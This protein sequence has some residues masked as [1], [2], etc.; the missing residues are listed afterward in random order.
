V[1]HQGIDADVVVVGA[2]AA[3][4]VLASR[5]SEDPHR[6]VLLVEAGGSDWNPLLRV[7]LMTGLILRS[8]YA[9][10][11]YVTE[12]EDAL[13]ARRLQWARGKVLGGSTSING[14]VYMRGL[15]LDYDRWDASGLHGWAYR[16][17]LPYFLRSERSHRRDDALHGTQGPMTVSAPRLANPL[18][19]AYREAA[20]QAGWPATDD[21]AGEKPLGVGAYDFNIARGRRVSASSAF[22]APARARPNL[23]VLTGAQALGLIWSGPRRVGGV[24]VRHQGQALSCRAQ[25]EV[26]LC[27][28]AVNSPQLLLLSG[29][30]PADELRRHG[31]DVRVD[32]PGVGQSLQDHL[33]VR[34]EHRATEGVTL[35]RLRRPDRAAW[36]LAQALLWGRGP[37]ASFPLEVGGLYRSGL[38]GEA[39]DLQSHFLPALSSAS[40]RLPGF[41]R[42]L[43]QD[44]GAGF[45]ANVF[46]LRPRSVGRIG[47]ASAD[48]LQP[49]R[50]QPRYLSDP[51]DLQV[52]RQGVRVLREIFR[53]RAFDR[54][55]A[56]ELSPGNCVQTDA[57]LEAW[58]RATADTVYHPTSSC[59]M[60]P[61]GDAGA[62]LDAQCRVRGVEN[63]RVADASS[64]P[65]VTS[66]NTAAPTIMLA[67]RVAD[68]V[69]GCAPGALQG[70][71]GAPA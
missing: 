62:V 22:L 11:G 31:V 41:G 18:F 33:L 15:P 24:V 50:I 9:N 8:A 56:E 60:G 71:G 7:P 55:R 67:E 13:N 29:I 5:L 51:H 63:L 46:Q 64:L 52:L 38:E 14:M 10:W 65:S 19:E 37:A 26:V 20:R 58:I 44:R 54:W 48:P 39:P 4:C 27:G 23:R 42:A 45:F 68:F 70:A 25:T 66:G 28:G 16:D 30:G 53:Q 21:F 49:P 6:K 69:R 17:V 12:P 57:E 3:G 2:G 1:K 43:P 47:L 34:V 61:D 32:L 40:I 35:D 36:A 59:R